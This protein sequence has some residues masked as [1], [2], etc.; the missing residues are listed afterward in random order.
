MPEISF[1]QIKN[2]QHAIAAFLALQGSINGA[3]KRKKQFK[4]LQTF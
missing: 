3:F 4:N 2:R 1:D